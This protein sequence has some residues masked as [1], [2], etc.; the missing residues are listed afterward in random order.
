MF[1]LGALPQTI[2]LGSCRRV[3]WTQTWALAYLTSFVIDE[4]LA[5]SASELSVHPTAS[6]AAVSTV[7]RKRIRGYTAYMRGTIWLSFT[8]A[9][10]F[11]THGIFKLASLISP[12]IPSVHPLG[13]FAISSGFWI[14]LFA[15]PSRL[16]LAFLSNIIAVPVGPGLSGVALPLA[17]IYAATLIY[18][19]DTDDQW[20]RGIQL[21]FAC[22]T[23]VIPMLFS[24]ENMLEVAPP[25][26]QRQLYFMLGTYFLLAHLSAGG[27][28]Y[29]LVYDSKSTYKPSWTEYLG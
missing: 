17:F 24:I 15:A 12:H 19:V 9:C 11:L 2:K 1:I 3:P 8:V 16:E 18:M 4:L 5:L 7:A 6:T 20:T 13:I 23:T 29:G 10:G 25:N 14:C 22:L 21:G 26:R 28:F 27:L